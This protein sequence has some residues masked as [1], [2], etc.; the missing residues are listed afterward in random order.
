MA[1]TTREGD[2]S[3]MKPG[4]PMYHPDM[5]LA[6]QFCSGMGIELGAAAHNS[7]NLPGSINVAPFSDDPSHTDYKD[8]RL[9]QDS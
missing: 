6:H 4:G 7:F 2:L 8:F 3:K 1:I 5:P 9:Y